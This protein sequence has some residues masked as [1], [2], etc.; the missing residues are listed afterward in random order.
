MIKKER[1]AVKKSIN[2][3]NSLMIWKYVLVSKKAN[4]SLLEISL[5]T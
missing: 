3:V 4:N 5:Q 2:K 1:N